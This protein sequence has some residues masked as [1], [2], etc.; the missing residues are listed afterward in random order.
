MEWRYG[1]TP[2]WFEA[3]KELAPHHEGYFETEL[4]VALMVRRERSD[5]RTTRAWHDAC[6]PDFCS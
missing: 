2:S 3:R 6:L 1:G 4:P 5:P